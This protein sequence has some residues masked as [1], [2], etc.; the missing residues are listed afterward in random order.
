MYICIIYKKNA[1]I[2]AL[3]IKK[4][5]EL[6]QFRTCLRVIFGAGTLGSSKFLM[7]LVFVIASQVCCP[8][9][10]MVVQPHLQISVQLWDHVGLQKQTYSQEQADAVGSVLLF[11]LL[12]PLEEQGPGA[13]PGSAPLVKLWG[14]VLSLHRE[15]WVANLDVKLPFSTSQLPQRLAHN[16]CIVTG[17]KVSCLQSLPTERA[18]WKGWQPL[19]SQHWCLQGPSGD[20]VS[21]AYI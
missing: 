18:D 15:V 3:Y 1:C 17:R 8:V 12:C 11:L 21:S 16:K 4:Y 14:L 6:L 19:I 2:Y 13:R 5:K 9:S 10:C 20:R 7:N